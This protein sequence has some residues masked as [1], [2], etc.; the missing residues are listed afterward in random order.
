[1]NKLRIV[2]RGSRLSMAQ[3]QI[4]KNK[5]FEVAP[6]ISIDIIT[7]ETSGDIDQQTPLFEIEGRDFFTKE[8]DAYLL[9]G[10]ADIAVHSLKDLSRERVLSTSFTN[11][12]IEREDPRD[13]CIISKSGFEKLQNNTEIIIGTSSLRRQELAPAFLEIA[14]PSYQGKKARISCNTVRGNIDSRLRQLKSEK[15]D[16]LI[17]AA[18]GLNRL[19]KSEES[20]EITK[21]LLSDTKMMWLPLIEC[22]PA[23]GQGALI[24]ECL[25]SNKFAA[26]VLSKITNQ[27]LSNLLT[28]E[29]ESTKNFGGG[30]HQRFG[31]IAISHKHLNFVAI[32]GKNENGLDVTDIMFEAPEI[33]R[34]ILSTTDFMKDFFSYAYSK[35]YTDIGGKVVFVTHHRAVTQD[36]AEQLKNK[37]VWCSGSKTWRELAGRGIWVEGCADGLGFDF[38]TDLFNTPLAAIS[39]DDI[40]VLTNEQSKNHW[41][42]KGMSVTATYKLKRNLS[43]TL[44]SELKNAEAVFWT[45]FMQYEAAKEYLSQ[46]VIHICPLGQTETSLKKAGIKPI[47]F[48][49][50]HTFNAWRKRNIS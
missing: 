24:A 35:Q 29:R 27:S 1:M 15:Y 22:T 30:C 39:Q 40:H 32:S 45:N 41:L 16:G 6:D 17:L 14:L 7:K 47:V 13:V 42:E 38:L 44:I 49:T 9:S 31:A 10:D 12:I 8:I 5:L 34:K 46:D 3:A 43:S 20:S 36:F 33:N 2:C 48:P 21:E 18:A 23:P 28:K 50:I 4:V 26:S 37:R 25:N 11:A 19:L